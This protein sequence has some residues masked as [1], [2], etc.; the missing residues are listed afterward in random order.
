MQRTRVLVAEDDDLLADMVSSVLSSDERIE[1]VGRAANGPDAVERALAVSPD[2]VLMDIHM[3]GMD[4]IAA[5]ATLRESGS[6]AR[7]VILTGSDMPGDEERARSA[8]AVGY[9]SK[10][11]AGQ[12]L[13]AATLAAA[14]LARPGGSGEADG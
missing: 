6:Q 13:V 11:R 1:I 10:E 2:V 4:G 9:V 3:P 12:E 14:A 5:A 7:V 8:G